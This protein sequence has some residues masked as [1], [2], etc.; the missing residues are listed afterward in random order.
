LASFGATTATGLSELLEGAVSHAQ[1]TR[2]WAGAQKTAPDLWRPVKAVVRE[3]QSETGGLILD[4]SSE[5]QPDTDENAMVCGHYE[6]STERI[7]QGL[8]FLTARYRSQGVNSPVGFPLVAKTEKDTAPQRQK[9]KRRRPGSQNAACQDLSKPAVPNRLPL[10][11]VLFEVGF[12]SA[13]PRRVLKQTQTRAFIGPL[14]ANRQVALSPADKS[15]GRYVPVETLELQAQ[16]TRDI[17]LEGV[18]FPRL[19]VT[20]VFPNEAGSLGLRS[21]V[22]R[23]PTLSFTALTT[24]SHERGEVECDHKSLKQQVALAKSPTHPVTTQTTH[25]FAAL[26]GFLKLERLKRKTKL[27]HFALK[28]KLYLNAL[29]AAFSTLRTLLPV[30]GSA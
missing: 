11:F 18:D 23:E 12:A 8:N 29:R 26:C 4:D 14:K 30:Q 1:V 5:E 6:H 3:V 21:L 20:Q 17:S 27:N 13:D 7:R 19:L 15:Q 25:C 24:P 22:S 2:D 28:S 10:R 16:A 9:A